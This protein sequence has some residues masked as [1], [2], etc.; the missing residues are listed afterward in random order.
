MSDDNSIEES[1]SEIVFSGGTDIGKVRKQNEDSILLC[2]FE[3]SDVILLVVADGVGGHDGGEVASKLAVETMKETVSN[4]VLQVNSGGGY[5]ENWLSSTLQQAIEDANKQIIEQQ[6]QTQYS[7]M[8]TTVVALLLRGNEAALSHLGD[9]RCY[10]LSE[11]QLIQL[12]EDHTLLQKMLNEGRI[13]QHEFEKSP[14]H[15]MISQAL[16]LIEHPVVIVEPVQVADNALLLLCSDG[17]NNC[18]SD[19]QIRKVL[20]TD[21]PLSD[22]VDELITRAND[23]G[24]VDNISVVLVKF[25]GLSG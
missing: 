4:A 25:A 22:M 8:A 2:G 9:S 1:N 6:N 12:T 5:F 21:N 18:I 19:D 14:M 24:G 3:H 13:T 11:Q 20:E 16:G 17:L 7:N 15:H 10:R 23:Y